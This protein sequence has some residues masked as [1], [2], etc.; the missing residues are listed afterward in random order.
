M[1]GVFS[2]YIA[3]I[4]AQA[5]FDA[6]FE[7][8][9]GA[10]SA[11][12][13]YTP[14]SSMP[15]DYTDASWITG[16]IALN[17]ASSLPIV[18]NGLSGLNGHA[19]SLAIGVLAGS[20]TRG[21]V[22]EQC[23]D[24]TSQ[25]KMDGWLWSAIENSEIQVAG[26]N[27]LFECMGTD[28]AAAD[29]AIGSRM[30][31]YASFLMGY[32]PNTSVYRAE[33]KTASGLHVYPETGLVALQPTI[34]QPSSVSAYLQSGGT[35]GRQFGACYLAGASVGPCAVIVNPDQSAG[36]PFPFPQYHHTLTLSGTGTVDGGTASTLGAAPPATVPYDSAVIAFP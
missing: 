10:L 27:K 7:D 11:F 4:A 16:E 8:N 6:L 5:H 26:K 15:C 3:S 28:S 25:P 9:S 34:S 33:Y 13:P 2:S 1:Q 18:I 24:S 29:V 31:A 36:R 20:N 35:Y 23:F 17:Q 19:P 14:F 32:D 30:Y 12:A 21:G 22:F